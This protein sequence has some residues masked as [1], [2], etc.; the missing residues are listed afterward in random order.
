MRIFDT[1]TLTTPTPVRALR[2]TRLFVVED[3][4]VVR[5]L[6][7]SV[8]ASIPGLFLAGEFNCASATIA[9][10][11][12]APPD[13]LLLDIHVSESE[14]MEILRV[15]ADEYPM[16]K[17]IVVSNCADLT[18][19]RYVAEYPM[20]E[21]IVVSNCTDLAHRKYFT[22]AGAYAFYDKGHGLCAMR[23]MRCMLEGLAGQ[24]D[25]TPNLQREIPKWR[26]TVYGTHH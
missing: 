21:V 19:R 24:I 6:W 26:R 15:I 11:R 14:G 18:H 10:I 1:E 13:V 5:A 20:S 16:T 25:T 3:S 22:K 2:P 23:C 4:D 17:V 7:R 8:A 9:A 12:R